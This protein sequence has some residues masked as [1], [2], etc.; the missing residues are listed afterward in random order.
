MFSQNVFKFFFK[1]FMASLKKKDHL[2]GEVKPLYSVKSKNTC[3]LSN[4]GFLV[5][6]LERTVENNILTK[7]GANSYLWNYHTVVNKK[8]FIFK[9]IPDYGTDMQT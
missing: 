4:L 9:K 3:K 2:V 5:F 1:T 7:V 8:I 6:L